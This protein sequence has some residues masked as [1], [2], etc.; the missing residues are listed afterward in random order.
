[1]RY[2]GFSKVVNLVELIY[3]VQEAHFHE[4]D[5]QVEK[6][7]RKADVQIVQQVLEHIHKLHKFDLVSNEPLHILHINVIWALFEDVAQMVSDLSELRITHLMNLE[8][9]GW[10]L[11]ERLRGSTP[12]KLKGCHKFFEPPADGAETIL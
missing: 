12:D 9:Q 11:D 10:C 1:M 7:F 2:L 4:W 5:H 8:D 3:R 6:E